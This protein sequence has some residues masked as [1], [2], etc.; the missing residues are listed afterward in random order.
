MRNM[1]LLTLTLISILALD[2]CATGLGNGDYQRYQAGYVQNVQTGVVTSVR[3]VNIAGN[4]S[5]LPV[6][7]VLGAVVGGLA[8]NN[9][10][11]GNG[12]IAGAVA[13]AAL[14][15]LAGNALQGK[16]TSQ[17]GLEI[18]VRLDSGRSIAVTQGADQQFNVGDRVNVL[19]GGSGTT[20]VM[21]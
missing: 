7:T 17:I 1:N 16:A 8:G 18:I 12:Q 6:G 3:N 5:E 13:G 4:Q 21:H 2:G 19:T 14:G 10:G 15:G 11:R 9:L 20:R